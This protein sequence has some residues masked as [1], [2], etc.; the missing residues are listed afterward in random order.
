MDNS[1]QGGGM[2][3]CRNSLHAGNILLDLGPYCAQLQSPHLIHLAR[4]FTKSGC[5]LPGLDS[6]VR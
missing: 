1:R 2:A 5:N 3:Y 6:V 4:G